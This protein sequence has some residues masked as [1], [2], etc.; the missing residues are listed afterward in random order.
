M[1]LENLFLNFLILICI[2]ED[3]AGV[4]NYFFIFDLSP[5]VVVFH[6]LDRCEILSYTTTILDIF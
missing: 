4:N 6:L 5:G 3:S 1:I 2:H